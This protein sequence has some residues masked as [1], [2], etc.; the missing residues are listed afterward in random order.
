MLYYG[1]FYPDLGI[2][3]VA[4][5]TINDAATLGDIGDPSPDNLCDAGTYTD[6]VKAMYTA[7]TSSDGSY[8]QGRAEEDISS[9]HYFVR[10]K[11]IF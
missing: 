6:Q 2:L 9:T 3:A 7:I 8:F 10:V 11:N 1:L 5:K 4:H